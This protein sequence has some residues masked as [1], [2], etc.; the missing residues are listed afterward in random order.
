M[1]P[2]EPKGC[3]RADVSKSPPCE[4]PKWSSAWN[5]LLCGKKPRPWLSDGPLLGGKRN[6]C[7]AIGKNVG[8]KNYKTLG[9][10]ANI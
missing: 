1:L 10:M 8:S 5:T 7:R 4:D 3:A 2:V 6:Q 9:Q